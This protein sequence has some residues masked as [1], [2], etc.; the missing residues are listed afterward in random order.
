[1]KKTHKCDPRSGAT[2]IE[3]ALLAGLVAIV[4]AAAA[5][6]FGDDLKKL[7]GATGEQTETVT[8]NVKTVDLTSTL[9]DANNKGGGGQQNP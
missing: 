6:F 1:M 7:F 4:V 5:M 8:T 9:K 3:Y 2:F